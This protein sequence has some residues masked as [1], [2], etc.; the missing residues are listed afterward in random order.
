[1]RRQKKEKWHALWTY[2]FLLTRS[3]I[4]IRRRQQPPSQREHGRRGHR[5]T[6]TRDHGGKK[7]TETE[8]GSRRARAG[9]PPRSVRPFPRWWGV[10]SF[11]LREWDPHRTQPAPACSGSPYPC[12]QG[13]D[14]SLHLHGCTCT[15]QLQAAAAACG[16]SSLKAAA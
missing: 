13:E 3:A 14:A 9:A 1:M 10:C 12:M 16:S 8:W 7:R 11:G 6:Q 2:L 5:P 15:A 4:I